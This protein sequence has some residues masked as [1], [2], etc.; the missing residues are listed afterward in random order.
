MLKTGIRRRFVIALATLVGLVVLVETAVLV[1]FALRHVRREIE[2][3]ALAYAELAVVPICE[4]YARYS[5][6]GIS[7]LHGIVHDT[8]KLNPDLRAVAVYNTAL[9]IFQVIND[10][11]VWS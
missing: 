9:R 7:K 10:D 1:V 6:S 4:A 5:E 3:R 11:E 8:A 2:Q